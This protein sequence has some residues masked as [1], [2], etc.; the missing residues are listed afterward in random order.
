MR[1][2]D[3]ARR[4]VGLARRVRE[5]PALPQRD[6]LVS[7]FS[8]PPGLRAAVH[9]DVRPP[10]LP[11]RTRASPLQFSSVLCRV[12]HRR[13]GLRRVGEFPR[14]VGLR[15]IGRLWPPR[16]RRRQRLAR[17][18]AQGPR[19]RGRRD[20]HRRAQLADPHLRRQC[21]ALGR[22]RLRRRGVL[23]H[24]WL[25]HLGLRRARRRLQPGLQV[26]RLRLDLQVRLRTPRPLALRRR[27]RQG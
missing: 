7:S 18:A 11:P 4:D 3:V 6:V 22:R 1:W 25:R 17:A 14:R 20:G 26:A 21:L 5:I 13:G 10:V 16:T 9:L 23:L 8:G 19:L 15:S 2:I 27:D 24:L 12:R